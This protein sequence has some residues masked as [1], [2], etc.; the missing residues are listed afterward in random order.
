MQVEDGTSAKEVRL[1]LLV[2]W[3]RNTSAFEALNPVTNKGYNDISTGF[4]PSPELQTILEQGLKFAFVSSDPMSRYDEELERFRRNVRIQAFFQNTDA[5]IA[6][7]KESLIKVHSS[8]EPSQDQRHHASE[9]YL[10]QTIN[11][12]K[13]EISNITS[14][15][16]NSLSSSVRKEIQELLM[17]DNSPFIAKAADKNMGITILDRFSVEGSRH[18]SY[19][20]MAS[21]FLHSEGFEQL[22]D[23]V[24]I[25][26]IAEQAFR[27][28]RE[29]IRPLLRN[30][31][32]YAV[33][34]DLYT[35]L[36][37]FTGTPDR[38]DT[39]LAPEKLHAF[40]RS[41]EWLVPA[42]YITPKLHKTPVSG[43]P[44][45]AG[46]SWGTTKTAIFLVH[47]LSYLLDP[48]YAPSVFKDTT[49]CINMV[50][51]TYANP[52]PLDCTLA[53][54]DIKD[55]YNVIPLEELRDLVEERLRAT[56]DVSRYTDVFIEFLLQVLDYTLEYA[57]LSFGKT[58]YK[59]VVGIAMGTPLGPLLA[60][61]FL[62]HKL[63]EV[64]CTTLPVYLYG[65]LLDDLF[66]V[67]HNG[68]FPEVLER[69]SNIHPSLEFTSTHSQYSVDYLDITIYK[70]PPD[71]DVGAPFLHVKLYEKPMNKHL[72]IPWNSF[73]EQ[74]ML[75]GTVI[76]NMVR[77]IR[78]NTRFEE[79]DKCRTDYV[80]H[81]RAKGYPW[82]AIL[83]WID[84]RKFSERKT[85]LIPKEPKH[86][87]PK[88]TG[89]VF[90]THR[91]PRALRISWK[92]LINEYSEILR[93]D[94]DFAPIAD[95]LQ[96]VIVAKK[97]ARTNSTLLTS[98]R[99]DGR[100]VGYAIAEQRWFDIYD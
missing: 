72:Y 13:K 54:C 92:T 47:M 78:N 12:M 26:D 95:R 35:F 39:V 57:V 52:L 63:D 37:N 50:E 3:A 51:A 10:S 34:S 18:P 42:F 86:L 87:R 46:H 2:E 30:R 29:L 62:A 94:S 49:M 88:L 16:H 11:L 69:L 56:T 24:D 84:I 44:I 22:A 71:A 80:R 21:K 70:R 91:A 64:V 36:D 23:D 41:T 8:W 19:Q 28:L 7:M 20:H 82:S 6:S 48:E 76:T 100:K 83:S 68:Y 65:R 60:N 67:T 75:R 15:F 59:Q 40:I 14:E 25:A 79:F 77:L 53:T 73:H 31:A 33:Q 81:L 74:S 61:L 32:P 27:R 55:L 99:S 9:I 45:T 38:P 90:V 89:M 85:I 96:K 4:T 66:I 1:R 97:K 5:E 43:R 17:D 93:G 58:L 98:A